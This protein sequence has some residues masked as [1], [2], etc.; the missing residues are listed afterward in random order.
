MRT[1]CALAVTLTMV[2]TVSAAPNVTN[3]TQKGSLLL[4]PDIR[5]D[6]TGTVPG[7][8]GRWNT[9]VR[10]Q[11][12]GSQDV[13][14]KCYWMDGNK[15][16]VDFAVPITRNQ[17]FW[18]DARTGNGTAQVNP[19][20]QG[21]AN[22]LDNPFL[23]GPWPGGF[24][25]PVQTNEDN[26]TSGDYEKGLL[27]CWA[28]DNGLQNQVKWNHLFGTATVYNERFGAYEYNAY[29]FYA[30]IGLDLEPIGTAGIINLD[31][32]DYDACP[33]YQIGQFS[34]VGALADPPSAPP[35]SQVRLAVAGCIL[36]LRQDYFPVYTK[37]DFEVWN[38]DEVKFTGAFECADSWHETEFE[39][40]L[41]ATNG[42]GL[43]STSQAFNASNLGTY[44]ARYRLQARKSTECPLSQA[45]PIVAVQSMFLDLTPNTTR[46]VG[47]NLA[48]AGKFSGRIT[49]DAFGIVPEG[50]LR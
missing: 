43:D 50:G 5:I 25:D 14:I 9:L 20:P 41:D 10:I 39:A 35:V 49:W 3:A 27:V 46:V 47:T 12:D 16:R 44:P 33:Q 11:N 8:Q 15:N 22:G 42:G 19:F 28:V 30:P 17:P 26:D 24:I 48:A 37:Y 31:G 13:T 1:L 21:A 34:P 7:G 40:E 29:S 45:T 36:T 23:A 6:D 4:F 32:I 38:E 18:F 2:G